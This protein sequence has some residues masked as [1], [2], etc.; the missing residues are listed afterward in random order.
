MESNEKFNKKNLEKLVT[1]RL[2]A[3]KSRTKLSQNLLQGIFDGVLE[4]FIFCRF[5]GFKI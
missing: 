2:G 5:T 4:I 1:I 3:K